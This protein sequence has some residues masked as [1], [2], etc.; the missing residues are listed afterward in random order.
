MKVGYLWGAALQAK[1]F[2]AACALASFPV[3]TVH[4]CPSDL[5]W[6]G[7]RRVVL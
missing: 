5:L 7:R 6:N 4:G 2:T 1:A 3:L